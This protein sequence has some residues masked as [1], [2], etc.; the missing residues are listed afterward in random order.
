MSHSKNEIYFLEFLILNWSNIL[1]VDINFLKFLKLEKSYLYTLAILLLKL[2]KLFNSL[3]GVQRDLN[4]N[5]Q[6][7]FQEEILLKLWE[8]V[9][10]FLILLQL[11]KYS[12][13][14]I[15]NLI[16]CMLKE[17]LFI[18]MLDK[19]CKRDNS[20]KPDKT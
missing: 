14:L 8:S 9:V 10:W 17:P 5:H 6:Q 19:V 1:F 2:K 11:L 16:L 20:H 7:L 4:Y 3:I 18:D 13:D 12:Q 15:I